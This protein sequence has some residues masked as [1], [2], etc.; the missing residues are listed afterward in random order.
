MIQLRKKDVY[1]PF[2]ESFQISDH[3][4]KYRFLRGEVKTALLLGAKTCTLCRGGI[5]H[6]FEIVHAVN[7]SSLNDVPGSPNESTASRRVQGPLET[8]TCSFSVSHSPATNHVT[9]FVWSFVMCSM[10]SIMVRAGC[11]YQGP[12]TRHLRAQREAPK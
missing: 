8:H 11:H 12:H 3:E 9:H 7:G 10:G 6:S 5:C 4:T 1:M 2:S